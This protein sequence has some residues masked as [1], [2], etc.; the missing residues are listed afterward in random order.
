MKDS[1][2]ELRQGRFGFRFVLTLLEDGLECRHLNGPW[3][4]SEREAWEGFVHSLCLDEYE[5]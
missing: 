2:L 5:D 4:R 3:R 1:K